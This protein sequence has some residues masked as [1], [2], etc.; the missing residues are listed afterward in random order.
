MKQGI[1]RDGR[2]Y[3]V[4][5]KGLPENYT[6]MAGGNEFV[7]DDEM[8]DDLGVIVDRTQ[9]EFAKLLEKAIYGRKSELAN[10][11]KVNI[12]IL[13]NATPGRIGI[14]YY[15]SI[16]QKQYLDRIKKWQ[17]QSAWRHTYSINK[18]LSHYYG[19]PNLYDIAK[20]AFGENANDK[21]LNH[22]TTTLFTC[23]VED[24]KF[25]TIWFRN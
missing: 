11:S 5:G 12:L 3:L 4:W 1:V 6:P 15:N 19:A 17:E 14:L 2:V 21:V 10:R 25:H 13:D 16:D 23:V 18:Q 24:K 9:E 8:E 20:A 22:A 7:D